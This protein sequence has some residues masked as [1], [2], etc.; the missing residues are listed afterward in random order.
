M[1]RRKREDSGIL[2]NPPE[3]LKNRA[4]NRRRGLEQEW[5]KQSQSR[6]QA[7]DIYAFGMVM[8][9]ILF[10][11]LPFKEGTNMQGYLL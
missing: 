9:E 1:K 7:G 3:L 10:R 11:A 2:Y 4:A 6:R 8:Y 5:I